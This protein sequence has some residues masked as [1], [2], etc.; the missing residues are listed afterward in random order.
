MV[1]CCHQLLGEVAILGEGYIGLSDVMLAL[2][3]GR[4]ID[5]LL[6]DL[7]VHDLTVGRFDEAI[8]VYPRVGR[9]RV[10][11][12]DVRSF[13]R[14][15]RAD[16][17]VMGG[18][19]VADFKASALAGKTARSQCREPPLVGDLRQGIGLIHE[20]RELR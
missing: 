5:H 15:D 1:A 3:D 10:D 7:A 13:W 8:F 14:L 16:A 18:V 20:L 6:S 12:A 17:A 9:E 2:L 11:E 4:E 19:H